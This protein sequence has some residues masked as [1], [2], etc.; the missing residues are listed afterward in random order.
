M[1]DRFIMILSSICVFILLL[2][3]RQPFHISSA[4]ELSARE[5]RE[6]VI[7]RLQEKETNMKE[8]IIFASRPNTREANSVEVKESNSS[9]NISYIDDNETIYL[10]PFISDIMITINKV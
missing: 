1:Y 3:S 9:S 10:T 6:L 2:L 7:R 4:P 5:R 8:M